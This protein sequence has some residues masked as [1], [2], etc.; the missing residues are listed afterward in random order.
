LACARAKFFRRFL[1]I[2][3]FNQPISSK[4]ATSKVSFAWWHQLS[5]R[6]RRAVLGMACVLLPVLVWWLGV[7]PALRILRAA[8]VQ[9][10]K[11]QT[12]WQ[13]MQ[14][15]AEQ[16]ASLK[17]VVPLSYAAS[18]AAL[19][20]GTQKHLGDRAKLQMTASQ[21]TV[22]LTQVPAADLAQWLADVRQNA[23]L[24]PMRTK[25]QADAQQKWSGTVDFQ[26]T[27]NG[28]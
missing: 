27:G 11:L 23:R 4:T 20:A 6:D 12:Q 21:A 22:L 18:K 19:E 16:A 26:W 14:Q 2:V 28:A 25:L 3:N 24:T 7:A 8:P 15:M 9:Q 13:T 5:Q 17:Q 10:A 1:T